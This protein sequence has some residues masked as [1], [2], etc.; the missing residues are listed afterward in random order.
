[1]DTLAKAVATAK[2]FT[3]C[4]A[5]GAVLTPAIP[6]YTFSLYPGVYC[7]ACRAAIWDGTLA[8]IGK[9]SVRWRVTEELSGCGGCGR[10]IDLWRDPI[11]EGGRRG[12]NLVCV[13][14]FGGDCNCTW[15][16]RGCR[17]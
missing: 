15:L 5:C 6:S 4:V 17:S 8:R 14:P 1:M 10:V 12:G 2:L 16:C 3:P 7:A 9:P 11:W 13:C